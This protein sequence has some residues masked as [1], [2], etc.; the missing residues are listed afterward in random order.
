MCP[1]NDISNM[2]EIFESAKSQV[3]KFLLKTESDFL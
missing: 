1:N 3:K 2:F